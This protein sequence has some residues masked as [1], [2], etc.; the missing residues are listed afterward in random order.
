MGFCKWNK[1]IDAKNE[2]QLLHALNESHS[3]MNEIN[4]EEISEYATNHFSF[5]AVGKQFM[6]AYDQALKK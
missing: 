4:R 1:L 3:E 6:N 2:A 5:E